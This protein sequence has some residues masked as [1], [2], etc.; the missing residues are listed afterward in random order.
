MTTSLT[1]Y[2]VKAC[3]HPEG[4]AISSIAEGLPIELGD[5]SNRSL[6]RHL[7]SLVDAGVLRAEGQTKGRRYFTESN[8][9][10][11]TSVDQDSSDEDIQQALVYLRRP[12]WDR[13]P[14]S[15]QVQWFDN[16]TPNQTYYLSTAERKLLYGH[17]RRYQEND[18]AGTYARKI[19]DRLLIDLSYNSSR[20]EGNTYS[21][22]E[23]ELLV[24]DGISPNGKLEEEKVMILN[25]KEA[26]QY[27]VDK[28]PQIIPSKETFSTLHYL[29]SDGLVDSRYSGYVRDAG[30]RIGHSTYLPLE[31]QKKLE[32]Q[33]TAIGIKAEKILDPFEQSLFLLMHLGYLQAFIDVNKRTSRLSANIPLVRS[34][35]VP[36]SCI[37]L[38]K[39]EYIAAMISIYELQNP[40]ALTRLFLKSYLRGCKLYDATVDAISFDEV[41]VRYRTQRR[42]AIRHII[43]QN[44]HSAR[45]EQ[46]IKKAS[47]HIPHN[48]KTRFIEDIQEDLTLL[49]PARLA[50]LGVTAQDLKIWQD[51][52]TK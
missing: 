25:H 15:Y 48:N 50:G 9:N 7:G 40:K 49:S 32:H 21:L 43:L 20:L 3:S 6:R 35:L 13:M 31:N 52:N 5:I 30:V 12:L 39:E 33:L 19:Y 4:A 16:Y 26:I 51:K 38:D 18:P 11:L 24:A 41:R 42:E 22:L 10:T 1:N 17:G 37:E 2:L 27:L 46:F 34:N 8:K 29:L 23:T 44:L 36:L 28:A 45:L 47:D 14:Q